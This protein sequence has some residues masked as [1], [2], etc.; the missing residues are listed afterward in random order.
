MPGMFTF[1]NSPQFL[2]LTILVFLLLKLIL[3]VRLVPQALRSPAIQRSFL[4]LIFVVAGSMIG[5]I[6]WEIKLSRLLFTPLIPYTFVLFSVRIAWAFLIPQYQALGLFLDSLTEKKY[7]LKFYQKILL[8]ITSL[9]SIAF[10]YLAFF[11]TDGIAE[12]ERLGALTSPSDTNLSYE[13]ILIR[14]SI[15]YVL[16]FLTLPNLFFCLKKIRSQVLPKILNHQL[17]I[18]IKYLLLPYLAAELLLAIHFNCTTL[19]PYTNA[20]V[21][22]SALLITYIGYHSINRIMGMRFLNFTSHVETKHTFDFIDDF[23][24]ILEQLSFATSSQELGQITSSFFKQAFSIPQAKT[25][26]YTRNNSD[27]KATHIDAAVEEFCL[28]YSPEIGDY[29]NHNKILIYDEIAFS[30]FYDEESK[31]TEI[32]NFLRTINADI[33]LPILE[34][35]QIIAYIIVESN[36]LPTALYTATQRDQMIIFAQYLG[37]I[38]NLLQQRNIEK[39]IQQEKELQEELYKKNQEID[40]Y[41]ESIRSFFTD[42]KHKQIGIIFY[43]NRRFICANQAANQ[44]IQC[45][46]HTQQGHPIAKTI[47]QVARQVHEYKSPQSLLTQDMSGKRYC[48]AGVLNLEQNNVII[49]MSQPDIGDIITKQSALLKD[50][51]TWDYMLY[52]ETT[53]PGQLIN[54]L[55]P[56]NGPTLLNF[57]INLLQTALSKKATLLELPG[58]DLMAMVELL[59]HISTRE[60]LLTLSICESTNMQELATKLLGINPIFGTHAQQ[61]SIL[62]KLDGTG[63]LFIQNIEHLALDLQEYL[64]EFIKFG[65]YHV[66]KSERTMSANVRI[67]C[68]ADCSL[69]K[70][71][72]QGGFSASLFNELKKCAVSMP[73]LAQL[74]ATELN[75]LAQG[76]SQQAI[77]NNDLKNL[78]GLTPKECEKLAENRPLSLQELKARIEELVAHKSKKNNIEQEIHYIPSTQITDPELQHAGSLGKHALRDPQIMVLLWNT[79]KNQNKIATFLGV[80]RSSVNRRCKEYLLDR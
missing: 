11:D 72:E 8:P 35:N 53:K 65:Y 16:G 19:N 29:I 62:Q 14:N 54:R 55:I 21:G 32:L 38:F 1:L 77:G 66:Y 80:N 75:E 44:M 69:E 78:L 4:F 9:I 45:N 73:S 26:L 23:R 33:F 48:I 12:I 27:S 76:Y 47:R 46:L 74:H 40:H 22:I 18:I 57:K 61:K 67:I 15:H 42:A 25:T 37:N 39:L 20:I 2:F 3:L 79:F 24:I 30:N 64:A 52:L 17:L 49:T 36:A 34:K 7:S 5:E 63:T 28:S 10:M 56:G 51:S 60:T 71:V 31:R 6:A 59:H 70:L 43:K 68:S 50:P 41:K 58:Q 13:I